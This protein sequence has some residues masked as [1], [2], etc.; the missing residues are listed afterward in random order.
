MLRTLRSLRLSDEIGIENWKVETPMDISV[1]CASCHARFKVSEKYAGQTGPCPKCKK[2][3]R[4]PEKS[5]EIVIHAPD[6]F[7]PKD[8]SGRGVLK[9]LEREEANTSPVMIVS[10]VASILAVLVAAFVI[11]KTFGGTEAGV[12]TWILAAGAVLLGP[13]LAV[14]GYALLRDSELEP[15]RGVALWTRAAACGLVFAVLWGAY[16]YVKVQVFESDIEVFHVVFIAPVMLAIGGLASMASLDLEYMN[17][18]M[19][20]GI[21]VLITG[22]LRMLMGMNIY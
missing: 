9:P 7:G 5:E 11:G 8:S 20:C 22:M 10:I 19:H 17:G 14:A 6:E 15:F 21:Y 4:I 13:P 16:Y 2:P 1:I 3:I 12:P 18:V